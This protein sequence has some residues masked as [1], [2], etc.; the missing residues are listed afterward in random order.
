MTN[1]ELALRVRAGENDKILELWS[2][3]RGYA[4]KQAKRWA[5][6]LNG[7]GGATAEDLAQVA[8]LAMLE[9]ANTFK[10]TGKFLGWYAFYIKTNFSKACGLRTTRDKNDPIHNAISM[11]TPIAD[12][13]EEMVLEDVLEDLNA[14][15]AFEEIEHNELS[16]IVG[17]ALD[18]LTEQQRNVVVYRYW[19]GLTL[20]ATGRLVGINKGSAARLEQRAMKRLRHSGINP[21]LHKYARENGIG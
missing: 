6:A 1:E 16:A 11:Q 20:E 4:W 19:Y 14:A 5:V 2:C 13:S 18:T 8:F 3:V 12:D 7:R 9:A 21:E 10:G 17:R 15:R